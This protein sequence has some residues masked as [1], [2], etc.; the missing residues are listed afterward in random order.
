MDD[1]KLRTNLGE[2]MVPPIFPRKRKGLGS[3]EFPSGRIRL[4]KLLAMRI[5]VPAEHPKVA[6]T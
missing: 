4:L 1:Y 6:C 3:V 2:A 5:S